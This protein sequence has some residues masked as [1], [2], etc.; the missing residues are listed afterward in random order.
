[1]KLIIVLDGLPACI[2]LY[3]NHHCRPWVTRHTQAVLAEQASTTKYQNHEI[4]TPS[5]N[6][7]RQL[8]AT[9][10]HTVT[11]Y[12]IPR[13]HTRTNNPSTDLNGIPKPKDINSYIS[14][15][16]QILYTPTHMSANIMDTDPSR[17]P[18]DLQ[19]PA[20]TTEL[21]YN[22]A[23]IAKSSLHYAGPLTA[24][25]GSDN[26][27]GRLIHGPLLISSRP[28]WYETPQAR[29]YTLVEESVGNGDE[30]K[31]TRLVLRLWARNET[32]GEIANLFWE[33][34]G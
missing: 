25:E 33:K 4:H 6:P 34:V 19:W 9:E 15:R 26:K 13:S 5:S 28:A 24:L 10:H 3:L 30:R 16:G 18:S 12:S 29:N 2:F 17:R 22:W 7:P 23:I 31:R 20:N 32:K 8:V 1:M 11:R 27:T 21:L 14:P